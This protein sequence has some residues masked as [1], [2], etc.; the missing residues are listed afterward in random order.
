M[1][2]EVNCNANE[3]ATE[4]AEAQSLKGC[5]YI[6]KNHQGMCQALELHQLNYGIVS[7]ASSTLVVWTK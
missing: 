4:S 5:V 3:F 6:S 2:G 1:N 7:I